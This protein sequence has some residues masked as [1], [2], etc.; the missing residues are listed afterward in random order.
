M[1]G[2]VSDKIGGFDRNFMQSFDHQNSKASVSADDFVYQ[3]IH[4]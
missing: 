3:R 2:L 4:V 1:I